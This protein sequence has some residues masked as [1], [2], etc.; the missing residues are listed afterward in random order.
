MTEQP[1]YSLMSLKSPVRTIEGRANRVNC[2]SNA[3]VDAL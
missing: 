3:L 1:K 2:G